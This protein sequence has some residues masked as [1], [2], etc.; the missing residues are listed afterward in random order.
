MSVIAFWDLEVTG[1]AIKTNTVA[2]GVGW[3]GFCLESLDGLC[4]ET[5]QSGKRKVEREMD[6]MGPWRDEWAVAYIN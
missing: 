6:L 4:V 1:H 3:D 5:V 2:G